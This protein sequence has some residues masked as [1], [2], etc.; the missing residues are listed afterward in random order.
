[1]KVIHV[2][3]R[4]PKRAMR[5]SSENIRASISRREGGTAII[6]LDDV[7]NPEF[8]LEIVIEETQAHLRRV[9]NIPSP[10]EN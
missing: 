10:L 3:G 8:H 9:F 2:E 1:M 5:L 7:V 6:R 4:Y